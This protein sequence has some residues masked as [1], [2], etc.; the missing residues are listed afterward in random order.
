M[1]II[2]DFGINFVAFFIFVLTPFLIKLKSERVTTIF[3]GI[4]MFTGIFVVGSLL[5]LT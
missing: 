1:N 2:L 5:F 3:Q 4:S